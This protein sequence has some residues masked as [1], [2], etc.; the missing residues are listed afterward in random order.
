[1]INP[2]TGWF[3]ITEID[4]KQANEIINRL[5]FTWLT[6]YP[7]PTEIIMDRGREFAAEV[8]DALDALKNEYCITCKLIT[9]QNPQANS[10]L[11]R[12]HKVLH[13]M[14]QVLELKVARDLPDYGWTSIL[15]AIRQAIRSTVH[16]TSRATPTQLVFSRDAILN[17]SCEANWQY[18]KERKQRLI[19]QNNK[20]KNATHIPHQYNVGDRV[21]VRLHPNRKQGTDQSKG[22]F[23]V[24]QVYDTGTVK[25][26]RA[27]PAGGAAMRHGTSEMW[28]RVWTD[29]P[30]QSRMQASLASYYPNLMSHAQHVKYCSTP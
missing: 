19:V 24:T 1:M 14:V 20:C 21:M 15:S 11:E 27:T 13:N 3:E 10:I 12:V 2:A 5:E 6:Q 9:T 18:I 22:P 25:L 16:T 17:V 23:T 8:C 29:H 4:I 30:Y 7:W 26:S 28:I